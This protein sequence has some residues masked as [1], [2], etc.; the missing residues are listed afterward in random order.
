[1]PPAAPNPAAPRFAAARFGTPLAFFLAAACAL[2]G[3]LGGLGRVDQVLYDQAVS[4]ARRAASPDILLVAIDDDSL[5]RLGRWPWPRTVHAALLDRLA[6]ARAIGLDII[7]SEPDRFD[8]AA[9][10]V[11]AAAVRRRG[12]VVLP[13]VLPE[14]RSDA[15]P[16]APVAPLAGTAAGLGFNNLQPDA[17]A[18]VRRIAWTAEAGGARWP[19]FALA[20]LEAGGQAERARR[21]A[22][23]AAD[24]DGRT[25]IPYVG[26]PGSLRA[27]SYRSVLAGEV[28]AAEIRGKYVLVG[29]WATGL[30]D[31]F[32]TPVSH[33]A[34]GMSGLE[35]MGNLLQAAQQGV[36]WRAASPLQNALACALPV[37]LLG[38]LLPRLSPRQGLLA[39]AAMLLA[40]LACALL[41]LRF[42]QIWFAPGAALVGLVL[43]YPLWS[44]RSQEAALRY[45]D[46]EL[47]RLR[48]EHPPVLEEADPPAPPGPRPRSLQGRVEELQRAL[49]RVRSLRGFLAD[50]LEGMSD[51]TLVFDRAGRLQFR[52][53]AA[54]DYYRGMGQRAP[55]SGTSVAELL[56]RTLAD[57]QARERV[58]RALLHAPARADARATWHLDL[59]VRDLAERY[60][61][62]KC[63]AIHTDGGEFAGTVVTLSDITAI[64]LAERRREQA[65]RF[66]S[67]DMRAPQNSILALVALNRQ[68][69]DAARQAQALDRIEHLAHRTLQLLDDFAFLARAE[70]AEM[71]RVELDL[72]ELLQEAADDFWAPASQRGIVLDI[73]RPLPAAPTV[74]DQAMLMRAVSNLMDNAVKYSPD[75]GRVECGIRAAGGFWELWLSDEG[76]GV[77]PEDRS[78]IFQPFVRLGGRGRQDVGGVGLGLAFVHTVARRHGGRVSLAPERTQGATFVL[79]LPAAPAQAGGGS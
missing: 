50:G 74:G 15:G 37:L 61:I 33:R 63:A 64:R 8:P 73:R 30:A 9:D 25:L 77:A 47:R 70:S 39:S 56:A 75:G 13:V 36:A 18:V 6:G 57:P 43:C 72:A 14:Q 42:A 66:I 49:A 51:A 59:E 19:H 68:T 23:D 71:A 29:S 35:I 20:L 60:L 11:L 2:L 54:A 12:N 44:W 53:R 34:N 62:L 46:G 1:V 7:F 10:R 58:R 67:H 26:P 40:T 22:G 27:V 45:M 52:N 76:P 69:D 38:L 31:A 65:L 4:A 21:M 79:R 16:Q 24:A 48:S 28:P 5:A 32:P 41:A 17:D 3:A 55:Q 78:R